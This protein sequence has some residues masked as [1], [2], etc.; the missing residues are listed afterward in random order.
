[1][2]RHPVCSLQQLT[3]HLMGHPVCYPSVNTHAYIPTC[4]PS[5]NSIHWNCSKVN[6]K[7]KKSV[8]N[9]NLTHFWYTGSTLKMYQLKIQGIKI[10]WNTTEVYEKCF[11]FWFVSISYHA[12][13]SWCIKMYEIGHLVYTKSM[14]LK[15][16]MVVRDVHFYSTNLCAYLEVLIFVFMYPLY[17]KSLRGEAIANN[18]NLLLV[19]Q[20]KI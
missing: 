10:V 7:C 15:K 9:G 3:Q 19:F 5:R 20:M 16:K 8:T 2:M 6:E 1:M 12:Y 17:C 4:Y 14:E 18:G 13:C 11:K